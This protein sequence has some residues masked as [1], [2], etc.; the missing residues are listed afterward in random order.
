MFFLKLIVSGL[1]QLSQ[2][3]LFSY[4]PHY[5]S[6]SACVSNSGLPRA[7]KDLHSC[8]K[9]F[10]H[11][12]FPGC[13]IWLPHPNG[14]QNIPTCWW[15]EQIAVKGGR[16]YFIGQWI[17]PFKSKI[18]CKYLVWPAQ[19]VPVRRQSRKLIGI[20]ICIFIFK[21]I[22]YP[23]LLGPWKTLQVLLTLCVLFT[24]DWE[25]EFNFSECSQAHQSSTGGHRSKIALADATIIRVFPASLI[26]FL[27]RAVSY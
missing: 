13:L 14:R 10:L 1:T 26:Y 23:K 7:V 3:S 16:L 19:Q 15:I 22:G 4:Y 11:L 17:R 6:G 8:S 5:F 27:L 18:R 12:C 25:M 9:P 21:E 2:W 20:F 24:N